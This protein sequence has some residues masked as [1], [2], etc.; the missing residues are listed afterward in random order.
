MLAALLALG[1]AVH[2]QTPDDPPP[3]PISRDMSGLYAE[4]LDRV[5]EDDLSWVLMRSVT[6]EEIWDGAA[7]MLPDI[8][9]QATLPGRDSFEN[10][11]PYGKITGT[12]NQALVPGGE[13]QDQ[14]DALTITNILGGATRI[15]HAAGLAMLLVFGVFFVLRTTYGFATRKGGTPFGVASIRLFA[16][17]LFLSPIGN[18][19]FCLIQGVMMAGAQIGIG[20]ANAVWD[21]ATQR[22][23]QVARSEEAAIAAAENILAIAAEDMVARA[24]AAGICR[25]IVNAKAGKDLGAPA[26]QPAL[27][28]NSLR[29]AWLECGWLADDSDA[30]KQIA[31]LAERYDAQSGQ[32]HGA[33]LQAYLFEV[34]D[35]R[36]GL[37]Q[38][39]HDAGEQWATEQVAASTS[40]W[41]KGK[42][43]FDPV[44]AV[45]YAGEPVDLLMVSTENTSADGNPAAELKTVPVVT[46]TLWSTLEHF[47]SPAG[48][49]GLAGACVAS[50]AR[51]IGEEVISGDDMAKA[52]ETRDANHNAAGGFRKFARWLN[53]TPPP[54]TIWPLANWPSRLRAPAS[55]ELKEE[56][57]T[58]AGNSSHYYDW[59]ERLQG[60]GDAVDLGRL[61]QPLYA[62]Q[63]QGISGDPRTGEGRRGWLMA[64][65]L[66]WQIQ[67]ARRL[68]AVVREIIA[69]SFKDVPVWGCDNE[70]GREDPV[71][72]LNVRAW[73]IGMLTAQALPY[74]GT[75][76]SPPAL[77]YDG[78]AGALTVNRI[79]GTHTI[80][81]SVADLL[82]T[83]LNDAA[84]SNA[85]L[86]V[87]MGAG[88]DM[89]QSGLVLYGV[90]TVAGMLGKIPKIGSVTGLLGGLA[91]G[92]GTVLIVAGFLLGVWLPSLPMLAWLTAV[93]AWFV[94]VVLSLLAAPLWAVAHAVPDGHG[95]MSPYSRKGYELLLFAMLRPLLQVVGLLLAITM[96]AL[97]VKVGALLYAGA[98]TAYKWAVGLETV[99]NVLGSVTGWIFVAG[100]A[101]IFLVAIFL[102]VH[103]TFSLCHEVAD[104]VFEWVGAGV[105]SL[106]DSEMLQGVQQAVLA[107]NT[108]VQGSVGRVAQQAAAAAQSSATRR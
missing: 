6:G 38:E 21:Q 108:R 71:A 61:M 1:G 88:T 69:P 90:G 4:M 56:W 72:C 31:Y 58:E 17:L 23:S 7:E 78:Q 94:S 96:S 34:L 103:K 24:F 84:A 51:R 33:T 89:V 9:W 3:P 85:P 50:W 102:L 83:A 86:T 53:N 15:I 98:I 49:P 41:G 52:I 36:R 105:R 60:I 67:L 11:D 68:D 42:L 8:V 47:G 73:N 44:G 107:F 26:S 82:H 48:I 59:V 64:G 99:D 28:Q 29:T 104:R 2:A 10:V 5:P 92:L 93:W 75:D 27:A 13:V 57:W 74:I 45:A 35:G 81:N 100:M 39:V 14:S 62:Q 87:L 54:S 22:F 18:Q 76:R 97:I 106:G 63:L 30:R 77:A 40:A 12:V 65:A 91:K 20:G 66:Y 95:A 101:I 70:N 46:Q 19:G 16:T 79:E 32:N 37:L 25:G 43:R 55:C 80:G